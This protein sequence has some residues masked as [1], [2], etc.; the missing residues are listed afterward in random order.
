MTWSSGE[1]HVLD[2]M[3]AEQLFPTLEQFPTQEL[4]QGL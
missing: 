2:F 3:T 1:M 4:T